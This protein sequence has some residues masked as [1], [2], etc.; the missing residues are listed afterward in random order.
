MWIILLLVLSLLAG[1]YSG[2][3]LVSKHVWSAEEY[4]C[5]HLNE[6][7]LQKAHKTVNEWVYYA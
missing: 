5:N 4:W 3:R 1:L 2:Q 7:C 6:M